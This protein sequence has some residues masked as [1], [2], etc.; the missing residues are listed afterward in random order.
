VNRSLSRLV[1][2]RELVEDRARLDLEGRSA[3]MQ[4]LEQSA[5]RQRQ[6]ARGIRND[7]V[8]ELSRPGP[9]PEEWRLKVRDAEL[10][11]SREARLGAL[12]EAAKPAV[13]QARDELVERRRDRRQAEILQAA[14]ARKEE[15]RQLRRDQNRT[16]DWFQSR[17]GRGKRRR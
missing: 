8:Q 15:K 3:E 13:D 17:S 12:A 4:A 10:T 5:E 1:R 7:A 2:I 14:A 11:G 16:D 9:M 6:M